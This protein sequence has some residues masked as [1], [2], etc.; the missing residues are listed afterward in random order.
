MRLY[1]QH[2]FSVSCTLFILKR[3]NAGVATVGIGAR[4]VGQRFE[5]MVGQQVV[6]VAHHAGP[7]VARVGVDAAF[8]SVG[9]DVSGVGRVE[10]LAGDVA[11][12]VKGIHRADD[13]IRSL[14][15]ILRF[16]GLHGRFAG[17]GRIAV[18]RAGTGNKRTVAYAEFGDLVQTVAGELIGHFIGAFSV[19][20]L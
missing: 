20:V 9:P 13:V 1:S 8:L 19:G 17:G 6:D 18:S 3:R 10:V 2:S 15:R 11:V 12:V 7:A 14:V 16:G 4:P 5:I